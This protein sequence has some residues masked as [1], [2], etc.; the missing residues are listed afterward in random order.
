MEEEAERRGE[1]SK[2]AYHM[3][4]REARGETQ[5]QGDSSARERIE[6]LALPGSGWGGKG[7]NG[8]A[9]DMLRPRRLNSAPSLKNEER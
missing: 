9:H 2:V 4:T 5:V 6:W 7:G 3:Y 1:P 8:R